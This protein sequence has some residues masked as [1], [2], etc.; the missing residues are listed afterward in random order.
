MLVEP[1]PGGFF[2]GD[3]MHKPFFWG[4]GGRRM[5]ADD[6][7]FEKR[8]AAQQMATGADFRPVASPWQGLARVANGAL[9]GLRMDR[10]ENAEQ[11]RADA[12]AAILD[13]LMTGA[14]TEGGGDP[15]TAAMLDPELRDFG[16]K[17]WEARQPQPAEPVLRQQNDGSYIGIN[18]ATGEVM[19]DIADPNPKPALDWM[20]VKNADGTTTLIPVGVDGPITGAS[21]SGPPATLPPDFNFDEPQMPAQV[22]QALEQFKSIYGP[23]EGERR[24]NDLIGLGGF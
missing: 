17:V 11:E 7:A 1:R 13:A 23:E 14:Q 16:M 6:L 18:P 2:G 19:F 12:Q 8:L 22:N 21:S 10:A 24:Y 5:S 20:S 3:P 9:G 4:A 15:V